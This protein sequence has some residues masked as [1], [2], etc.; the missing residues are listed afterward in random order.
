MNEWIKCMYA[1]LHNGTPFIHKRVNTY[2][3]TLTLSK[4]LKLLTVFCILGNAERVTLTSH[5]KM[6]TIGA[7]DIYGHF[8]IP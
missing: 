3:C 1:H 7:F 2:H 6:T 5:H 8:T 4:V